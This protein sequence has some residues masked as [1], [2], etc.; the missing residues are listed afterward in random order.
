MLYTEYGKTKQEEQTMNE[1]ERLNM[2]MNR[3][4]EMLSG[5]G[6]VDIDDCGFEDW[7]NDEEMYIDDEFEGF[8]IE[9]Y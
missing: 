8:Y 6:T 5:Y 1:N 4:Y 9:T 3:G 7:E 2:L